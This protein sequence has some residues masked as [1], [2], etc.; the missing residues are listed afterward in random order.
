MYVYAELSP[1]VSKG[2]EASR[3]Y[4]LESGKS[5][6]RVWSSGVNTESSREVWNMKSPYNFKVLM[7][8]GLFN[9]FKIIYTILPVEDLTPNHKVL[10]P[11]LEPQAWASEI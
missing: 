11:R 4:V 8:V 6:E 10:K 5:P 7:C 1:R 2:S 9:L 3:K